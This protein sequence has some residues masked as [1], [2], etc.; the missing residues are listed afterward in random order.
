[1]CSA[2]FLYHPKQY[3]EN[4]NLYFVTGRL[5]EDKVLMAIKKF[6]LQN[7]ITIVSV[8]Y[9]KSDGLFQGIMPSREKILYKL[10]LDPSK[11]TILYAPSWEEGLSFRSF[12][13]EMTRI[14][15][16]NENI[17]IIIKPHPCLL[18]SPVDDNYIF[19]TGG[20]N[21]RENFRQFANNTNFAF[22]DSY[23]IDEL[24]IAADIMISD[25]SSVALEFL[26]LGKPVIYLDCPDF[27]KT[28]KTIY[29]DFNDMPYN[30]L[31]ANPMCNGG[32][33][34]GLINYDYH[35]ILNDITFIINNQDYKISERK[36]FSDLLL[37]NKGHA[38]EV[39]AQTII[40]QYNQYICDKNIAS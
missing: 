11:K 8:G 17:N 23:I 20:I 18:V 5:N 40:E 7:M 1:M 14:L 37:V 35:N 2:K 4:Y 36:E 24:L 6:E 21:W 16:Q 13:I 25:I 9:P 32:R 34:V 19:Y 38:S 27:E 29:K 22:I 3:Y 31:L 30:D 33:H 26:V 15:I 10:G 28:L 39:C 12:G